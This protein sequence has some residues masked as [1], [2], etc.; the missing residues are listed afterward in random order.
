MWYCAPKNYLNI[1]ELGCGKLVV[2]VSLIS[3]PLLAW[4]LF[5]YNQPSQPPTT[6]ICHHYF[7]HAFHVGRCMYNIHCI[8]YL[9]RFS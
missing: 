1:C 3:S 4:K 6:Y 2:D 8:Y 7:S 9:E 5:T